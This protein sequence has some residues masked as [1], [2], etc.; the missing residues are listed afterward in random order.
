MI[1]SRV[2]PAVLSLAFLRSTSGP[3]PPRRCQ[4]N[5]SLV[6]LASPVPSPEMAVIFVFPGANL[7]THSRADVENLPPT[8]AALDFDAARDAGPGACRE[9]AAHSPQ[10]LSSHSCANFYGGEAVSIDDCFTRACA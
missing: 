9:A 8:E 5:A 7:I 6:S 4:W 3:N 10:R 1:V 2:L